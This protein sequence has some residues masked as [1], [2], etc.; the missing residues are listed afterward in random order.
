MSSSWVQEAGTVSQY[1]TDHTLRDTYRYHVEKSP[2]QIP[3]KGTKSLLVIWR[4]VFWHPSWASN[5]QVDLKRYLHMDE[6]YCLSWIL[7]VVSYTSGI[8]SDL[9]HVTL[10]TACV[11]LESRRHGDSPMPWS[12]R[13]D[14][15]DY[16]CAC[17][18][19][20]PL[21]QADPSREVR[22]AS[23][24]PSWALLRLSSSRIRSWKV[25]LTFS[26]WHKY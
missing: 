6:I 10:I 12:K 13:V 20:R 9:S 21:R 16:L 17:S 14:T 4:V 8:N 2:A 3:L 22:S 15:F 19:P 23:V 25:M 11:S 24:S 1:R 5:E 18:H 7:S 26:W